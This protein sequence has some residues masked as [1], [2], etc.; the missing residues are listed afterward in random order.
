MSRRAEI[1]P[2]FNISVHNLYNICLIYT[3]QT[4]IQLITC[5]FLEIGKL[6][7]RRVDYSPTSIAVDSMIGEMMNEKQYNTFVSETT[8]NHGDCDLVQILPRNGSLT[9][10][11]E[12]ESP[13]ASDEDEDERDMQMLMEEARQEALTEQQQTHVRHSEPAVRGPPA[14]PWSMAEIEAGTQQALVKCSSRM[15]EQLSLISYRLA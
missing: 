11:K 4:K 10:T 14:V 6:E 8:M 12:S 5:S 13:V 3:T 1:P 2:P 7:N 15:L 9:E